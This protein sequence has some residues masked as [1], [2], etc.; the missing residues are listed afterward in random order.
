[1]VLSTWPLQPSSD[2]CRAVAEVVVEGVILAIDDHEV[3]KR[4]E[5]RRQRVHRRCGLP[6]DRLMA[7]DRL[8]DALVGDLEVP[9]LRELR[10]LHAGRGELRA[11]AVEVVRLVRHRTLAERHVLGVRGVVAGLYP[12]SVH[13][14]TPVAWWAASAIP[15]P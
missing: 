1:M 8:H 13:E 12:F 3:L 7:T 14:P 15:T 10:E 5:V 11:G 9:G 6:Y 4:R 2:R